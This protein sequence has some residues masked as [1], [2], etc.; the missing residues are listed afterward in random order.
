[1]GNYIHCLLVN[2]NIMTNKEM[3]QELEKVLRKEIE[4]ITEIANKTDDENQK[5]FIKGMVQGIRHSLLKMPI[6]FDD[7]GNVC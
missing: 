5:Q 3:I 2:V 7:S 6:C 1:M 4:M